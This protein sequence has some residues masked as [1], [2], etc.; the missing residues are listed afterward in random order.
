MNNRSASNQSTDLT[1]NQSDAPP[2]QARRSFWLSRN[3][4]ILAGFLLAAGYFLWTEHEAH[5]VAALPWLLVGGCLVM[6][7]FMHRGHG[8]GHNQTDKRAADKVDQ[9]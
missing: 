8:G 3:G 9:W 7:L 5:V 4:L 1:N 2:E 6:H